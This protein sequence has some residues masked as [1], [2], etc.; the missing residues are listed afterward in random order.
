MGAALPSKSMHRNRCAPPGGT[1][2]FIDASFAVLR[3]S[4]RTGVDLNP[5]C[6]TVSSWIWAPIPMFVSHVFP[7]LVFYHVWFLLAWSVCVG[8]LCGFVAA[9]LSKRRHQPI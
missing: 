5:L 2:A 8:V 4:K 9:R 3:E 7:R 1:V 6:L